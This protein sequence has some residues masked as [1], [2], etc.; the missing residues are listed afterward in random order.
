MSAKEKLTVLYDGQ[1]P[2]CKRYVH[3]VRLRENFQ[4]ELIDARGRS[5]LRDKAT[6]LGYNLD[7]GMLVEYR[8]AYYF[9]DK[10]VF[11]LSSLTTPSNVFNKVMI[12]LF[13]SEKVTAFLYPIMAFFRGM[14]LF[15]LQ[16]D[17]IE[18]LPPPEKKKIAGFIVNCSVRQLVSDRVIT[19]DVCVRLTAFCFLFTVLYSWPLWYETERIFSAA[20]IF[21]FNM[22]SWLSQSMVIATLGLCG[23]LIIVPQKRKLGI[24]LAAFIAFLVIEDELRWQPFIY[25]YTFILFAAAFI[26][27]KPI[28]KDFRAIRLMVIGIYFWA[29][30][31]KINT[32]FI[33]DVFPWFVQPLGMNAGFVLF[34]S[35]IVPF[36]ECAIG[37][38]LF[39]PRW[40]GIGVILATCMLVVVLICLGPFG[41]NWGLIVWPWN[42]LLHALEAVLFLYYRE[43]LLKKEVAKDKMACLA[44]ALFW[45]LPALGMFDKWGSYPSF[46]LYSGLPATADVKFAPHENISHL[47]LEAQIAMKDNVIPLIMIVGYEYKLA[48]APGIRGYQ[49]MVQGAKGLCRKLN[50]PEQARLIIHK[51]PSFWSLDYTTTDM[52]LCPTAAKTNQ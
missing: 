9:G 16:N 20:P 35:C 3:M 52:A 51:L 47:P 50:H 44:I 34:L 21:N 8:G 36:I 12:K 6:E 29:G 30:F 32:A 18:N 38:C 4:V 49:N 46:M 27:Q 14:T 13:A 26:P 45:V 23:V 24:V 37:V 10:A 40:R 15:A 2:F 42:V 31:Y 33:F 28:E 11:L 5:D 25:M 17:F 22:P 43:P 7:L 39:V 1:C 48:V 41:H 19:A